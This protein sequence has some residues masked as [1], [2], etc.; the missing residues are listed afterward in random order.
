M[1]CQQSRTFV[2]CTLTCWSD[3]K[4]SIIFLQ[5]LVYFIYL[6]ILTV[7]Y[8]VCAAVVIIRHYRNQAR[9][10]G[11]TEQTPPTEL[12]PVAANS[13]AEPLSNGKSAQDQP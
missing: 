8:F 9:G 1:T 5:F 4:M 2:S 6:T 3:L 10:E 13:E 11:G 7:V 12:S